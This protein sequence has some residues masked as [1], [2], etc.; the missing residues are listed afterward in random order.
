MNIKEMNDIKEQLDYDPTTGVFTRKVSMT[1]SVKIG[2]IAGSKRNYIHVNG[3]RHRCDRLAWMFVHG[4][5]PDDLFHINMNEGDCRIKN[6]IDASYLKKNVR[7]KKQRATPDNIAKSL[8]A[9]GIE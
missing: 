5:Y 4:V 3:K 1:N 8:K 6:L 9:R 2:E 7:T